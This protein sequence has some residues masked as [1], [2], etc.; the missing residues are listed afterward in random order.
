MMILRDSTAT[1]LRRAL[2]LVLVVGLVGTLA[3]LLLMKHTDGIWQLIPVIL[4]SV[5]LAVLVWYAFANG[6]APVRALQGVMALFLVAGGI[7]VVQHY[8]GNIAYASDSNPGLSSSELYLEAVVGSTPL[9]A[10]GT[11]VQFALIGLAF[12]F[13]HPRLGNK[14]GDSETTRT[15]T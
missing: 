4:I 6:R 10:P 3:E 1:L 2:L 7:G 14:N 12:T 15:P 13:R 11:M 9:L 5:A 8:R